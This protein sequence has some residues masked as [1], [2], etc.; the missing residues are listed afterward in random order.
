MI[1]A[2]TLALFQFVQTTHPSVSD[3]GQMALFPKG[4]PEVLAALKGTSVDAKIQGFGARVTLVQT[5]HNPSQSAVEAVYT[6]PLPHDAA[7][8]RMRI[9]VGSR[10]IEGELKRREDARAIY[11]AAKNAGQT[12]ALLDQETDNV[13][14]QSIANLTP[15][16]DVKVEISYVQLLKYENGQFEFDFPMVVGPRYMGAS[17]PHPDKI[18]PV[19]APKGTR[20]GADIDLHV[21]LDAG[22]PIQSL[23][24]V[25]HKVEVRR[26]GDGSAQV[27]LS[28]HD[29]IPNRDFILRYAVATDSVQ[30]AF[31]THY[32]PERG[33]FF[34]MILLPP[35]APTAQ[36]VAPKELVF[37]MDQSGS[38]Q[39]FPLEKSKELT[40]KLID[41]MGPNDTF[42]VLGFSDNVTSLWP[43]TRPNTAENRRIASD[44]V[45]K[46]QVTGGTELQKAVVAALSPTPDPKRLRYVV[47][48]TDGFVGQEKE[49]LDDI[50]MYRGN[51]RM[52]V[53]GIGNGVNRSLV[54]AMSTEGCGDSEVVTLAER[55]DSAVERFARRSRNPILTHLTVSGTGLADILPS[56]LPDVLS[57]KPIVV[58]GRYDQP[59]TGEIQLNGIY[60]G[61]PWQKTLKVNLSGKN[62]DADPLMRLW[63]RRQ[64]TNLERNDYL[65]Q[66]RGESTERLKDRVTQVALKY[67]IMSS[68]TSFVAVEKRVVNIGG[69]Q[70]TVRVPVDMTEGVNLAPASQASVNLSFGASLSAAAPQGA[71]GGGVNGRNIAVPGVTRR[72]RL[73]KSA[74]TGSIAGSLAEKEVTPTDSFT[75]K[76]DAQVRNATGVIRVQIGLKN[77][78][79]AILSKLQSMGFKLDAK[80]D[81]LKVV[82]GT[83]DTKHLKEIAALEEVRMILS[84]KE[85]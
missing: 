56:P 38:Q 23:T 70:R 48:N 13:F 3:C 47:F 20:S 65:T 60:E 12:A 68:Y 6:F 36:Q 58:Y 25:L 34:T 54:D 33:G 35:K 71:A 17:T 64:I 28:K 4:Q 75:A 57:D 55:A 30:S 74:A 49:I 26:D 73:A 40:L 50:K 37:V 19:Y 39:G 18:S 24:S 31:L 32:E 53:F 45:R 7:V 29:E 46:M 8:D 16:A 11:D 44:F 69:K 76:T 2:L 77:L 21:N 63:A 42:N 72:I 52:F 84:D 79:P 5:F 51:S 43:E 41:Q 22:A 83:L 10:I 9:Q 81:D 80:L 62:D 61:K 1:T 66:L 67:G 27:S 78:S 82:L 59:G 14:T 85:G 15:G